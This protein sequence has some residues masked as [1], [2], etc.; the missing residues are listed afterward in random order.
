MATTAQLSWGQRLPTSCDGAKH[1]GTARCTARASTQGEVDINAFEQLY[2]QSAPR[3]SK[4]LYRI[5]RNREDAE[6]ALQEAFLNAYVHAKDF[7]GRSSFA[8][9]FTR[10]A[11]NSALMIVRKKRAHPEHSIDDDGGDAGAAPKTWIVSDT[12]ANPE[13]LYAQMECEG[14]LKAAVGD[15]RP[16][17]RKAVEVGQ[18]QDRSMR[19]TAE[20]LGISVAAAKARLFHARAA[21]RK[22]RRLRSMTKGWFPGGGLGLGGTRN[23][24]MQRHA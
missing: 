7:N 10:I 16:T 4:T 11:I 6:D 17:I 2:E 23:G 8:T 24:E 21:L 22:S 9:W 18:L 20:A 13:R 14:I 12:A 1:R 19:E 15:L 5:T 3:V